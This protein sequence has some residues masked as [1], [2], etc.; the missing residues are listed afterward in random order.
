M[1]G[2]HLRREG[3]RLLLYGL[4]IIVGVGCLVAIQSF[5]DNITI[6]IN[7]QSRQLL[8]A[9][10]TVQSRVPFTPEANRFFASIPGEKTEE[11]AL[12]TMVYFPK[13]QHS[14]L[15]QVR[16]LAG[17][18]PYFGEFVTDPPAAAAILRAPVSQPQVLVEESLLLQLQA[19]I[20]DQIRIGAATFHI[21]GGLLKVPGESMIMSQMAPRVYI[22]RAELEHTNL[23]QFGSRIIYRHHFLYPD[24]YDARDMLSA[25]SA[26]SE[27]QGFKYETVASRQ[28]SLG[29]R[30]DNVF[31]LLNMVAFLALILG[32]AGI[33]AAISVYIK[34]QL[35]AAAT[36]RCLGASSAQTTAC[37]LLQTL[38]LGSFSGLIGVGLGIAIQ[39]QLP[40]VLS[41]YLPFAVQL[42][43]SLK[44]ILLGCGAGMIC[45]VL[46]SLIPLLWLR[47][48]S[49]LLALR[50]DFEPERG[51]QWPQAVVVGMIILF[52]IAFAMA[53]A[54]KWQMGLGFAGA[55]IGVLIV[56]T[57]TSR[58]WLSL[59]RR[60]IGPWLPFTVRQGISNLYRPGNQTLIVT[61]TLGIS[62]FLIGTIYLSQRQLLRQ[63]EITD[64][65]HQSN[66]VLFDVQIDQRQELTALIETLAVPIIEE[67][68]M[69]SMRLAAVKNVPVVTLRE[70]NNRLD[71]KERIPD[72][73]LNREYRSTYRDHLVDSEALLAGEFSGQSAAGAAKTPVSLEED[74]AKKLKVGLGDELTFDVQGIPIL[75]EITSL[76]KV[77][78]FRVQPNFF[79]VFPVGVLEAAPQTLII[80]THVSDAAASARLQTAVVSRFAN[81]S[82]IDLTLV[83]ET[84]DKIL[85]QA[86]VAIKFMTNIGLASGVIVLIGCALAT[87]SQRQR[88]H[89]LLKVLGASR[90]K[91]LLIQFT[92]YVFLGIFIVVTGLS[93][94]LAG[95]WVLARF[96][97]E[98]R[99]ILDLP[100]LT[101]IALLILGITLIAGMMISL[102]SYRRPALE[103]LRAEG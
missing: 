84:M 23:V 58:L 18:Y 89:A 39:Y 63:F 30:L 3:L 36:L 24:G 51:W 34:R 50:K 68:P 99:F 12:T 92:E 74:I 35:P 70:N 95:S 46:F 19:Q 21:A 17:A 13:N 61:L 8:G 37:Y 80:T 90:M 44:A 2:R 97:F 20:G 47:D 38:L 45:T 64:S 94:A 88:E 22:P 53:I 49:P 71:E 86:L 78:W 40:G 67:V 83:L 9:D 5:R 75:C 91:I 87:Q 15:T 65:A 54:A 98:T 69:V 73:I 76:R 16:A 60:I 25:L 52:I 62:A 42:S 77:D 59:A 33:G 56:L 57:Y 81:I 102:L 28:R 11:L 85:N 27:N 103:V 82:V 32:G 100:A 101:A 79:A 4:A 72:W 96:V 7:Q 48:A 55:I 31:L 14:R 1:A 93:W 6:A 66:L 43:V 26:L 10:L 41:N 29:K